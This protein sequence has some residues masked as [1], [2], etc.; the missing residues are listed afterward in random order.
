MLFSTQEVAKQLRKTVSETEGLLSK[1]KAVPEAHLGGITYYSQKTIDI[2]M[3]TIR[4]TVPDGFISLENVAKSV[5]LSVGTTQKYMCQFGMK[6]DFVQNVGKQRNNFLNAASFSAFKT[7][8]AA[9]VAAG[10]A[11]RIQNLPRLRE[12][13]EPTPKTAIR[14]QTAAVDFQTVSTNASIG[15]L[16]INTEKAAVKQ[17]A[18]VNKATTKMDFTE[19]ISA[20]QTV[21]TEVSNKLNSVKLTADK[22][23]TE[24]K[25][26]VA[27]GHRVEE[28]IGAIK[29][30][31]RL[32]NDQ[33]EKFRTDTADRLKVVCTAVQAM[34]SSMSAMQQ[35]MVDLQAGIARADTFTLQY[36]SN[37]AGAT[38]PPRSQPAAR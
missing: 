22:A 21:S 15:V 36:G 14:P 34:E 33:M 19:V 37:G 12:E 29:R 1:H 32:L 11:K 5:G 9:S 35:I 27:V 2:L 16:P 26:A 17:V 28:E 4:N 6:P 20:I 31:N 23:E 24:A 13:T 25:N 8:Y 30:Q 7:K 10:V 3:T 38:T 18:V